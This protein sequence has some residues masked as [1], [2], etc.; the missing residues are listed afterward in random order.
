[1]VNFVQPANP[2][3]WLRFP[4]RADVQEIE[5]SD[6]LIVLL[7]VWIRFKNIIVPTEQYVR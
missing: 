5:N 6:S 2:V 4:G 1:M 7:A 3:L